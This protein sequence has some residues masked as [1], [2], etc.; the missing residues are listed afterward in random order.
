MD[1]SLEEIIPGLALSGYEITSEPSDVY[2]CIAWAAGD[3]TDWWDWHPGAYWPEPVP[4]RREVE[5]LI[6]VFEHLGYEVCDNGNLEAGYDKV[7]VY[8]CNGLWEHAA[9]QLADG[10]W[11]SKLG[12]DVDI[13]HPTPESLAGDIFGNVH[14]IM[15][16]QSAA[17]PFAMP[18]D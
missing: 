16:R 3:D 15:R 9:R 2:N 13:T 8:A 12:R 18:P 4:R 11:T 5:Y 17:F 6:M 10:R 7:A 1:E 14:C